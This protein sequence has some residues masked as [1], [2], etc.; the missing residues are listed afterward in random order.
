MADTLDPQGVVEAYMRERQA[1]QPLLDF[2]HP[3]VGMLAEFESW[4]VLSGRGS[5]E[6]AR[7]VLYTQWERQF[8]R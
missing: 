4:F 2:K 6:E 1:P 7:G 5:R 3:N 8:H